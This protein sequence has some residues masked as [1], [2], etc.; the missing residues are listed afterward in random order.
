M[1]KNVKGL[2]FSLVG[3]AVGYVVGMAVENGLNDK[4]NKELVQAEAEEKDV[5]MSI[6]KVAENMPKDEEETSD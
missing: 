3:T 4:F 2:V 6:L 1:A 5:L